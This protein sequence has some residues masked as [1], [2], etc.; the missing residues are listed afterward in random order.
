LVLVPYLRSTAWD[1]SQRV[2]GW[3][4]AYADVL[5]RDTDSAR[6]RNF[7]VAKGFIQTAKICALTVDLCSC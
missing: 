6:A 7:C 5:S 4:E 2:V 1:P 3:G